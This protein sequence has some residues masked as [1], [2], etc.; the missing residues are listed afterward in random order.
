MP[1][2]K[3]PYYIYY[4]EYDCSKTSPVTTQTQT[5]DAIKKI[6]ELLA[7]KQKEIMHV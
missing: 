3:P 6:D 7:A 5:D 4:V 2:V 1:A